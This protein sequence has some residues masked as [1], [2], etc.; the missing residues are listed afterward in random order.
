MTLVFLSLA[1]HT[2]VKERFSTEYRLGD[3]NFRI[4][5]PV[6]LDIDGVMWIFLH[7]NIKQ[8][9]RGEVEVRTYWIQTLD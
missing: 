9:K 6:D 2:E 3:L 4:H 1:N 5:R 7:T 8:C